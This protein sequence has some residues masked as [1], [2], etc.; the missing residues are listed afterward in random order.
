MKKM[1]LLAGCTALICVLFT[2][3]PQASSIENPSSPSLPSTVSLPVQEPAQT[4][5]YLLKEFDKRIALFGDDRETPLYIS[6]IYVS[7]LP[8][9]DRLLLK[10][11]LPARSEK[12]LRRLLEDYCS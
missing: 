2:A 4:P 1:L 5:P 11:G 10:E 9:A 7:Q 3:Q 12:E 8:E 6:D